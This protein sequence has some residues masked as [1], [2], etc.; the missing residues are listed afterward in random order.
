MFTG[1]ND[2]DVGG[3]VEDWLV[4]PDGVVALLGDPVVSLDLLDPDPGATVGCVAGAVLHCTPSNP[5]RP[6]VVV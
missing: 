3:V 2:E 4:D 6:Q 5:K 1:A